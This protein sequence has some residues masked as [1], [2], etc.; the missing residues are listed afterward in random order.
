MFQIIANNGSLKIKGFQ[1][2]LLLLLSLLIHSDS[3]R[4]FL[5]NVLIYSYPAFMPYIKYAIHAF[6]INIT[7]RFFVSF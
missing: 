3:W 7:D 6:K 1:E 5:S 4:F 2:W